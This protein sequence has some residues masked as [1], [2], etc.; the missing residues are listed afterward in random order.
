[1][2][3]V[4]YPVYRYGT[5][6]YK[7]QKNI[8]LNLNALLCIIHDQVILYIDKYKYVDWSFAVFYNFGAK[9]E[10]QLKYLFISNYSV[11]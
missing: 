1:M 10:Q 9:C 7:L 5:N 8:Y 6:I 11:S 2:N 3:V 4:Y